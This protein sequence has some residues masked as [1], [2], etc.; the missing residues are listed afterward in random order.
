M[1]ADVTKDI[2]FEVI[3]EQFIGTL[4]KYAVFNGRARR[5]EFWIF[6]ICSF[7]VGC[8]VGW[9][10]VIGWLISLAFFVPSLAVGARRLH[11]IDHSALLLLLLL[12]PLVGFIVLI[13]FWVQEGTAGDNKYGP[14]PKNN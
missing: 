1:S 14:N 2:T 4:K 7:V 10:P 3:K 11:D 9:I 6:F 8:V 5:Q 12:I 13:V